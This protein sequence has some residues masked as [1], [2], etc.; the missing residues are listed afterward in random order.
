MSWRGLLE[1]LRWPVSLFHIMGRT[2][3]L[4]WCY[5]SLH[6]CYTGCVTQGLWL[7]NW[8]AAYVTLL[9]TE[10]TQ[11]LHSWRNVFLRLLDCAFWCDQSSPASSESPGHWKVS[12]FILRRVFVVLVLYLWSIRQHC[13]AA[14]IVQIVLDGM[15]I[16]MHNSESGSLAYKCVIWE[17]RL[18]CNPVWYSRP[19]APLLASWMD[20]CCNNIQE[21]YFYMLHDD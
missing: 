14:C 8:R 18:V 5:S 7:E 10:A 9:C 6:W 20:V 1:C 11:R 4:H 16:C 2:A 15:H 12:R 3:V 17:E 19:C 21:P 13:A